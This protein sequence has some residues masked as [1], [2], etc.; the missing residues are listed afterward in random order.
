ML[1]ATPL[2]KKCLSAA[3]QNESMM[4]S[5]TRR[6][7]ISPKVV[8]CS[9]SAIPRIDRDVRVSVGEVLS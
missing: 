1:A 4:L 5:G 6:G 2:P 3:M 9:R 8:D 7:L